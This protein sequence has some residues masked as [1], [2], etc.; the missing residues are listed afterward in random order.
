MPRSSRIVNATTQRLLMRQRRIGQ[1]KKH[2]HSERATDKPAEE[3]PA[4]LACPPAG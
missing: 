1:M 4:E 3:K 2:E